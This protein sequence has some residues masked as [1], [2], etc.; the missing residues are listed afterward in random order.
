[1]EKRENA[2][3]IYIILLFGL[4]NII[5]FDLSFFSINIRTILLFLFTIITFIYII[6][7]ERARFKWN[8]LT[9]TDR[10]VCAI[11]VIILLYL[12]YRK[13]TNQPD[14]DQEIMALAMGM[15]YFIL[16][17]FILPTGAIFRILCASN[18]IVYAMMM[19]VYFTRGWSAVLIEFLT[20]SGG[21]T[22][23][24]VLGVS[25]SILAYCTS[26]RKKE[27]T[28]YGTAMILGSFLLFMDKNM[29][30]ILIIEGVLLVLPFLLKLEKGYV[31]SVME[32]FL[33]FNFLLCNM[34][35]ITGYVELFKG[36]VT[37][38][39]EVS[40]YMEMVL[41]VAALVFFTLWDKHTAEDDAQDKPLPEL[42]QFFKGVAA[43]IVI[44][45]G[46][47]FAAATRGSSVILPEVIYKLLA[48]FVLGISEQHGIFYTAGARY[49]IV[50]AI[51]VMAFLC[52]L[53]V[54]SMHDTEEDTRE[55]N[56]LKCIVAIYII[57]GIFLGQTIM[58]TPLYAAVIIV[59]LKGTVKKERNIAD[60]IDNSDTVL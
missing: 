55:Q 2:T 22:A 54:K 6:S 23:W 47:L 60:E 35:L 26:D 49:G 45:I 34:S 40:V 15:M 51:A 28:F 52:L 4:L 11:I 24:L 53:A 29:V 31:K 33:I 7:M 25:I 42:R 8:K 50:G 46:A 17:D 3:K 44:F 48:L 38:D 56:L 10:I 16:R 1:M 59:C 36:Y 43:A 20:G 37:Y 41:A 18:C 39:L 12:I 5:C 27:R 13:C 19:S 14:V 9:H 58:T 32:M 21:I 57:Q 30:A